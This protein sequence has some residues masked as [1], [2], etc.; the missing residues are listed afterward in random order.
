MPGTAFHTRQTGAIISK[1][2]KLVK[3]VHDPLLWLFLVNRDL[4][5]QIR[6]VDFLANTMKK[7]KTVGGASR[8]DKMNIYFVYM[9]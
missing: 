8:L 6:D 1:S 4:P 3:C 2:A 9:I 7:T 5:E